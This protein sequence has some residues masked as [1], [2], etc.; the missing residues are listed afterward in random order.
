[1]SLADA[2]ELPYWL[3]LGGEIRGR[4]ETVTGINFIP[5]NNDTYYLHRLR[6]NLGLEPLS[7]FHAY[8]QAQ[9]SQAPGYR[10]RPV[11][12][13]VA[14]TLDLRLGYVDVIPTKSWTVRLGRQELSYGDER[15]VGAS[16]WSNTG[17]SFDA[18]RFI[19]SAPGVRVDVFSGAVVVTVNGR[20]DRPHFNNKL[21]GVYVSLDRLPGKSVLQ[22]YVF[23]KSNATAV[24]KE[25]R[26]GDLDVYT[27]GARAVGSFTSRA[28]YG[29]EMALQTGHLSGD[30]VRAWAGHWTAGYR[31]G[32]SD[33]APRPL[34]EYNYASGDDGR[35]GRRGTF[36]QLYPTD[37]SKYGTADRIPWKNMHD[38]MGG[39]DW[40]PE[41]KVRVQLDYHSFWLADVRD[42]L[43]TEAG[44][45]FVR[46]PNAPSNWIGTEIDLQVSYRFKERLD[47]GGGCAHLFPGPYLEA[48]T[49]NSAVT[50]PYL[51]W[52]YSF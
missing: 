29:L 49:K 20:F 43:Y 21:H 35:P 31:L 7:W 41:P 36:D 51:M 12:A 13:N 18:A 47:F 48:S 27:Y 19:Y 33:R 38:L 24:D 37:H 16:N 44:A 8:V 42:A 3:K 10:I 6:L 50:T 4:M 39:V 34:V 25:G 28:D 45:P 32:K 46:D 26:I 11:P 40:R 1:M 9:D 15:L 17:R 23:W 22:P 5:G 30:T 52:T 14:D 2:E